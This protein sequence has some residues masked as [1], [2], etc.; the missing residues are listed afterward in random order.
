M[1]LLTN[2]LS[3]TSTAPQLYITLDD[4][5]SA[6]D[7]DEIDQI[8][9]N[10]DINDQQ[11][12]EEEHTSSVPQVNLTSTSPLLDIDVI[13]TLPLPEVNNNNS[14]SNYEMTLPQLPYCF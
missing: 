14:F 7:P 5:I 9:S 11:L 13:S 3:S 4:V 8:I 1:L 6:T 2:T 12:E 10:W